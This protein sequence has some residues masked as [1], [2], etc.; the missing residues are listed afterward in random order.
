MLTDTERLRRI[1]T[2]IGLIFEVEED[3]RKDAFA[4]SA[5][6]TRAWAYDSAEECFDARNNL[7]RVRYGLKIRANTR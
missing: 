2:A 6:V 5:P 7:M 4:Q 1:E 3:L